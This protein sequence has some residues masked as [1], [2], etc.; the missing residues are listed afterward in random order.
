MLEEC[1]TDD[2]CSMCNAGALKVITCEQGCEIP[3]CQTHYH[4]LAGEIIRDLPTKSIDSPEYID[5]R[6]MQ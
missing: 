2:I 3:L 4:Q 5:I 1:S 6:T